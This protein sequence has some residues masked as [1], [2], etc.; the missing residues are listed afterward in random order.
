[1]CNP[2]R[3]HRR[4]SRPGTSDHKERHARRSVV[5]ADT[6]LCGLSL[7]WVELFEMGDRHS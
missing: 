2:V 4:L 6:V 1:M 3:Q 5:L 7:F